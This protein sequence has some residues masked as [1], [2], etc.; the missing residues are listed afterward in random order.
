MPRMVIGSRGSTLAL[1]QAGQVREA[2]QKKN[3]RLRISILPIRTQGDRE[4]K[5]RQELEGRAT[6]ATQ[7]NVGRHTSGATRFRLLCRNRTGIANSLVGDAA[8][9][10]AGRCA[11]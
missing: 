7:P 2:L 5:R 1:V 9:G 4:I 6:G 3:P 11:G 8:F 10:D